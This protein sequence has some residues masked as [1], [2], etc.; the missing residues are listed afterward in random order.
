MP[1]YKKPGVF[2]TK[3]CQKLCM[4]QQRLPS[5]YIL[6]IRLCVISINLVCDQVNMLLKNYAVL[7]NTNCSNRETENT[8]YDPQSSTPSDLH[9]RDQ[10]TQEVLGSQGISQHHLLQGRQD[11]TPQ[12]G[13]LCPHGAHIWKEDHNINNKL[14]CP[15]R[16]TIPEWHI[17]FKSKIDFPNY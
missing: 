12:Q 10:V 3:C 5:T 8:I 7:Q 13:N 4:M 14:N 6:L 17:D 1:C 11:L 2:L 9:G 15:H 16:I